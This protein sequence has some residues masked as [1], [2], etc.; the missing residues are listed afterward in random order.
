[1]STRYTPTGEIYRPTEAEAMRELA[2]AERKEKEHT[3]S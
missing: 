3:A 2:G 1:M